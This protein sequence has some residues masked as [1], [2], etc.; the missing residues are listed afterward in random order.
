MVTQELFDNVIMQG[1]YMNEDR[2]YNPK[3]YDVVPKLRFVTRCN[4]TFSFNGKRFVFSQGTRWISSFT[5]GTRLI[6]QRDGEGHLQLLAHN[7]EKDF[8]EYGDLMRKFFIPQEEVNSPI[9][10]SSDQAL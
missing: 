8:I 3:L 4:M 5:D 1:K 2:S 10:A 9:P 6:L 7:F